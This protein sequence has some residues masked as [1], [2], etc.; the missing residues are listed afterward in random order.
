M[1]KWNPAV[2]HQDVALKVLEGDLVDLDLNVI[3]EYQKTKIYV[4]TLAPSI[5]SLVSNFS[6]ISQ[7]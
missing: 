1:R 5:T 4:P 7:F 3:S 2:Q 6:L